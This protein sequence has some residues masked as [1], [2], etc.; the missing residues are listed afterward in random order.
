M[1]LSR[2]LPQR[3]FPPYAFLPGRDPHPTRDPRGHSAGIEDD[4]TPQ[5][6]TD[7]EDWS[8]TPEYLFGIDLYNHG[9]LWEA[10]EAWEALWHLAKPDPLRADFL[11]GLIQCTAATLKVRMGQPQGLEA[12]A[13][14]GTERL[15][16]VAQ[17]SGGVYMRLSVQAFLE[18]F[19]AF[20]ASQP[21]DT[22]TRPMILLDD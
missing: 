1:T 10:H 22:E 16:R 5:E 13:R 4:S 2:L 17:Q 12:L 6:L 15:E 8:T 20:A 18:A 11:Q 7:I 19:R 3:P 21:K 9:Y 14:M